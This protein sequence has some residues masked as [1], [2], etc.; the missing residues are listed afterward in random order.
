MFSRLLAA[1]PPSDTDRLVAILDRATH[2]LV[3]ILATVATL[4]LTLGGVR[5]L[6][7]GGDPQQVETGDAGARLSARLAPYV[8]G[9]FAQ[10][11]AGPTTSRPG[12]LV[13]PE[14]MFKIESSEERLPGPVDIG[15]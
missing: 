9:S 15:G 7:A 3:A 10:L 14:S 13:E 5:Y 12:L 1:V 11:F 8:S 4:Y 6:L 2:W